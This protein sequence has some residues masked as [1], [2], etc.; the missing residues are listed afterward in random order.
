MA[1]DLARNLEHT[2]TSETKP[3]KYRQLQWLPSENPE[4]LDPPPRSPGLGHTEHLAYLGS[5]QQQHLR[6]CAQ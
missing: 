3:D 2:I 5:S 4:P 6:F 1:A